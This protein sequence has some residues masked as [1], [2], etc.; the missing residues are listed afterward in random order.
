MKRYSL[1]FTLLVALSILVSACASG[2][3]SVEENAP[4]APENPT[5]ILATTTSTQDSGLLDVLVPMF[6]TETGYTVKTVAV[7]TGAAL[8]MAEEGNA[9]VLLVHAPATV[10]QQRRAQLLVDDAR[11]PRLGSERRDSD[12]KFSVR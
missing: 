6:E 10:A 2:G 9:D 3:A 4:A 8:K 1:L 7:G 5:L 11:L 12:R